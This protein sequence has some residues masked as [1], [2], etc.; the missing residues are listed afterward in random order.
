MR[1]RIALLVGEP[2]EIYQK[3]FIEGF[4][5][6][7]F[8]CDC[9]VCVFAMYRKNQDTATRQVGES[10]IFSLIQL[11][12]FDAVVVMFDTI[13]T[14]G[15]A[16]AI[17]RKL[18][19]S[20]KGMV[21][22]IDKEIKGFT[23]VMMDHYRPIKVLISHL[24]EEHG[25]R[26]IAFLTGKQ[27]HRH[28]QQRLQGFLDCMEEH[29]LTVGNNR[30][31]YGDFWYDSG[32]SIVEG[33][34]KDRDHLPEAIACA[35]DYMAVG[36]AETLNKHGVRVPEEVAVVGYDSVGEG[37][38]SPQPITSVLLPAHSLGEYAASC[39]YAG[40]ENK[41]MEEFCPEVELF[42]GDSCGCKVNHN[43]LEQ[44]VRKTWESEESTYGYYSNFNHLL[45]DMLSRTDFR[46]LMDTIQTYTYQIREFDSF[47]LCLNDSWIAK[48]HAKASQIIK[49]GYTERILPVLKCGPA[50]EGLDQLNF[51][52]TFDVKEML[53]ELYEE[54]SIPKAFI[55]T[56]IYFEDMCFGYAVIGYGNVP[57]C[58]DDKYYMW[59]RSVMMGLECLRRV[60]IFQRN[61][62]VAEEKQ[63]ID[64]LS[65]MFNYQG[66]V[67]HSKPM[68]E[69]A[70]SSRGYISVM[71]VDLTGLEK[72][73]ATYGRGEG[74]KA[75]A[76]LAKMLGAC[77]DEESLCCRLGNDE[78][79]IAEITEDA[80][81]R[82]IQEIRRALSEQVEA[83]NKN[84]NCP[85]PIAVMAGARTARVEN[86]TD[87]EQLINAAVS[88]KNGDKAKEQR[89]A[90][91]LN[92]T[93]EEQQ[94]AMVVKKILEEN[95]LYYH[96]QPIVSAKDGSV[97]AYEALMR[98]DMQPPVSPLTIIKY[99]TNMERLYDV[100]RATFINVSRYILEHQEQF[101][102]KK[103][104]IN[105]IPGN[106][107]QGD[108]VDLLKELLG[109][110]EE[111]GIVVELTE[112]SEMDDTALSEMKESFKR[113]NLEIAVDDYGT[114]YSNIVNLLRYM[115]DYVKIDRMLLSGI[116][117]NPQKQHFVKD[118]IEFAHE[119]QF[120]VLAEGIE[121]GDEL[122][123]VVELNVDLIQ[124]FYTARPN[125]EVVSEIALERRQEISSY[126]H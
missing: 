114:G 55:F 91:R 56:P 118:I 70:K 29:N 39:V 116:H 126:Q 53:P 98:S 40:L 62:E 99:A 93:P 76:Q 43:V 78:F 48:D 54:R 31:F 41:P 86:F 121:N 104:F 84:P 95:L 83:Y 51:E 85:Y 80:T 42:I 3:K 117:N 92:I 64:S 47:H 113:M 34:L 111:T 101:A 46:G 67:K 22:S 74:D 27:Y 82:K 10:N 15:L 21:V 5:Q 38:T 96:F 120:K 36:V 81:Q 37:Q 94:E 28:S 68:I 50:G 20:Y 110:I 8:A 23:S 58:Y 18:K 75:I 16:K 119:N 73:N 6:Q 105:S 109:G 89:M 66:F 2:G 103:V 45:E 65:G 79:I 60:D 108:D 19:N 90:M 59:L 124:G 9:D 77:A 52:H 71:A 14:Q 35:N 61:A 49:K 44:L 4:F 1:K 87:M 100:E 115:P 13:H 17:E 97:Y 12:R 69:R 106:Q 30:V 25:Y 24:I 112:Q 11:D 88:R 63:I 123:T 7:A 57:K 102:G 32:I 107:L 72:I 125:A 122:R 33:L 26:D